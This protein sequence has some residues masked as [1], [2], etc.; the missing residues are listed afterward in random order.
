MG[1]AA[2]VNQEFANEM[3]SRGFKDLILHASTDADKLKV[4]N[5]LQDEVRKYFAA[6]QIQALA[7]QKLATKAAT[8]GSDLKEI[9]VKFCRFGKGQSNSE[10]LDGKRWAKFCK[11]NK[12][13]TINPSAFNPAGADMVFAKV[14]ACLMSWR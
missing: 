3:K 11:E 8:S 1:A 5:Q 6:Q 2:S 12:F 7:R 9:F 14:R 10:E 4:F 13:Y